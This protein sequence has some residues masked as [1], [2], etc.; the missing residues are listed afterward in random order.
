MMAT[1]VLDSTD[2]TGILADAGVTLDNPQTPPEGDAKPEAK[3]DQAPADKGTPGVDDADDIE[4]EDGLT[5]RQKR[6][7]TAAMQKT[8]GKKHRMQKEAEEFA[9]AQYNEKRLAEERAKLL[10]QELAELRAKVNP[11]PQAPQAPEKPKREDFASE[12]EY[13]DAMIQYGVDERLREKAAED[14]RSAAERARAQAIETAQGRIARA[15]EIVPDFQEVVGAVDTVVP[16]AIAGYMQKS[17]MFAELSYHLAKNQEL[18]V[19]LAKLAPDEQLVKIGRIESTL[20]PFEPKAAPNGDTPSKDTPNGQAQPAPS[21]DTGEA[22][23]K[24]RG[25]AAPVIT[26]LDGTGSAGISKDSKDM[27]IRD[28]IEEYQKRNGLNLNMRKR[29]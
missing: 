8:I 12:Y 1:T 14:A 16:P 21:A 29:H 13:V 9:A 2:L 23:S 28:H 20:T 15:V 25:N 5:P 17:E 4:G 7:F 22:P 27:N 18:L 26:P 19:S 24:P 10:E 6:E 3:T 11:Q